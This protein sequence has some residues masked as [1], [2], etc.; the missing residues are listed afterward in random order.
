MNSWS[1]K[2]I[3]ILILIMIIITIIG[4]ILYKL[5][6][7]KSSNNTTSAN[8]IYY[9]EKN[10]DIEMVEREEEINNKLKNVDDRTQYYTVKAI[11][12]NYI[13]YIGFENG[14]KL[15]SAL[16]PQY[17]SKYQITDNNIFDKL[18]VPK[19][20]GIKQYYVFRVNN[21]LTAQ[22]D[23]ET[24]LYLVNGNCR[25]S[26]QDTTFSI[27]AMVLLNTAKKLYNIY[28]YQYVKDN[29]LDT[30]KVGDTLTN[31]KSE[32]ITDRENNKYENIN[33]TDRE[34][35]NNYF[36]DFYELLN[37]Y[38]DEA[39][40]KLNTDYKN[41]RF[42][43][44][45]EFNEYLTENG[46]LLYLTQINRYKVVSKDAYVDYICTDQY[47]NTYTFRQQGGIMQYSVFLDDYTIMSEEEEEKYK[48]L[49]KESKATYILS[50]V[51]IMINTKDYNKI[52][53][54][55]DNTFKENNFSNVNDLKNY[56]KDNFYDINYI[57]IKD[58]IN[59]N[60]EY[61]VYKCNVKNMQKQ[62]ESK[63]MMFAIKI[64][65]EGFTMSF[66]VE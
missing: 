25:I 53:N 45:K 4:I 30:L 9:E 22:L 42:S 59:Q 57:E 11:V 15:K 36:N 46:N 60:D 50:R 33:V 2:F 64:M 12:S 39:Y 61:V 19:T 29:K 20:E 24:D 17:I 3:L 51:A 43:S 37:Y 63:N 32:E 55:L 58:T 13:E 56:I 47:N 31:F 7:N 26:G 48:N 28:P 16:S 40:D 27:N 35:A 8:T 44:K 14:E 6:V 54:S 10:D 62:I 49:N 38:S 65:D 1:K 21:I 41:K 34:M 23:N 18:T 5:K 52:Y 66:G